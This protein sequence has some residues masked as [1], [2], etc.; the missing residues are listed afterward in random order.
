[1]RILIADD[2]PHTCSL[3][4]SMLIQWGYDAVLAK[5]G[6][7][8]LEILQQDDPPPLA[9]LDRLMPGIDGVTLCRKVRENPNARPNYLI[10]LTGMSDQQDIVEGLRAGA[11]DYVTKPFN[12]DELQARVQI[13]VRM[14]E[15]QSVL[16]ERVEQLETALSHIKRLQ[17]L[18]PICSYCK[19]IRDDQKYWQEIELYISEHSDAEF[20]H[21]ICPDCNE[22][23]V[24]P[25]IEQARLQKETNPF[26]KHPRKK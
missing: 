4:K 1:M 2:D 23:I 13:G 18:L 7:E 6:K 12:V 22:T 8:A 10:L 17:G 5:N 26:N 16:M 3:L 21:V 11:D 15:L 14:I 25:E 9:I 24:K 20:S 19:R